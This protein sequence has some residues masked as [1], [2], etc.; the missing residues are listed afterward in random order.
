VLCCAVVT[1]LRCIRNVDGNV[2]GID[3]IVIFVDVG[4]SYSSAYSTVHHRMIAQGGTVM[5]VA[6]V[7]YLP[8]QSSVS[9]PTSV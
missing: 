3:G 6:D 5:F 2:V 8:P 4:V 7:S 9:P 1:D